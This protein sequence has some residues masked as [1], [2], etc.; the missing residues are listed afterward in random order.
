MDSEMI[1]YNILTT[2]YIGPRSAKSQH[3]K[4]LAIHII[5]SS[6]VLKLKLIESDLVVLY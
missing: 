6:H 4:K 5:V 1:T 2:T 3:K